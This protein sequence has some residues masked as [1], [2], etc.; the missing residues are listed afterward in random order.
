MIFGKRNNWTPVSKNIVNMDTAHC[1]EI[2][3][4]NLKFLSQGQAILE[5]PWMTTNRQLLIMEIGSHE[6]IKTH[7]RQ[8]CYQHIPLNCAKTSCIQ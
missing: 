8:F 2:L 3:E 5:T 6:D 7:I 4:E 1:Q